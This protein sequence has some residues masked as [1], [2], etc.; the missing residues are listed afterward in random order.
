[1]TG[2]E[3]THVPYRGVGAGAAATS[4]RPRRRDVRQHR[5]RVLPQVEERASA[6]PGGDHAPSASPAAPELPTIA[7]AGVPGFDVSSW[8]AFFVP[9][10][11][12]ARDRREDAR[13]HRGGAGAIRAVKAGWSSSASAWSARRPE[14]LGASPQVRDGQWGPV[15]RERGSRSTDDGYGKSMI[16]RR[17]LSSPRRRLGAGARLL[18]AG[19]SHAQAG[20]AASC[21]WSCLT[22]RE[23][24]PTRLPASS[25]IR[26]PESGASRS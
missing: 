4:S 12:P 14:E 8:F 5:P 10:K 20:R 1:M 17:R 19:R 3:M 7:E 21:A 13:R 6:R 9:A 2:I 25:P 16:D 22:R 23:G 18:I 11:T 15:I 24:R 26:S